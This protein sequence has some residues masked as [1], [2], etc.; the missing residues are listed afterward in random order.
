MTKLQARPGFDFF[1]KM[2]V[3][4]VLHSQA[5][6][7][8]TVKHELLMKSSPGTVLF[9]DEIAFVFDKRFQSER[10]S[11]FDAI[12]KHI[13]RYLGDFIMFLDGRVT[14]IGWSDAFGCSQIKLL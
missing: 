13:L 6:L 5:E 11:F 12:F 1:N 7:L 8:T 10:F 9:D 14:I 4:G 2:F 3:E